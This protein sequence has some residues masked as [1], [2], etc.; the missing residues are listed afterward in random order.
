MRPGH[1]ATGTALLL[2]TSYLVACG[3]SIGTT[4]ADVRRDDSGALGSARDARSYSDNAS[5]DAAVHMDP[6]EAGDSEPAESDGSCSGYARTY[7]A[8]LNACEPGT[9]SANFG[10]EC[11]CESNVER[12]CAKALSAPGTG[13]TPSYVASCGTELASNTEACKSG[14]IPRP[15]TTR[16]ACALVGSRVGGAP[17]GLDAQCASG[18]C[19]VVGSTCGRCATSVTTAGTACGPGTEVKR[20]VGLTCG[21]RN[22][23]VTV[24]G[25]G[26]ACD[27]GSTT[28]CVDGAACVGPTSGATCQ[29]RGVKSGTACDSKNVSDTRLLGRRGLLLREHQ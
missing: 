11:T 19:R 3:S 1:W 14:P 12:S 8:F 26:D 13:F 4:A 20:A 25:V 27:H 18:E 6:A 17:C 7:C 24:V 29:E 10:S 22:V 23:C 16:H 5:S 21:V 9:L 28:A 2:T 15:V